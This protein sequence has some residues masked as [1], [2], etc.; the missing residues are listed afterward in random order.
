MA[1][2]LETDWEDIFLVLG[3]ATIVDILL[4]LDLADEL[5]RAD[6]VRC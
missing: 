2:V 4:A 6:V 1:S 5:T 3:T